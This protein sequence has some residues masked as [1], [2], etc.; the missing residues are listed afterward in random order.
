MKN[1]LQLRIDKNRQTISLDM[2]NNDGD[3][4]NIVHEARLNGGSFCTSEYFDSITDMLLDM[5]TT[6]NDYRE[7]NGYDLLSWGA[8]IRMNK[9]TNKAETPE[10]PQAQ[11]THPMNQTNQTDQKNRRVFTLIVPK[12]TESGFRDD[13]N[14]VES[15]ETVSIPTELLV[16]QAIIVTNPNGVKGVAK[17]CSRIDLNNQTY[18]VL[19]QVVV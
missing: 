5:V 17:A 16:E 10:T 13:G 12:R 15:K 14:Y 18:L 6:Y 8:Y 7:A 11:T 3:D 19:G 2:V 9:V 4:K 1:I